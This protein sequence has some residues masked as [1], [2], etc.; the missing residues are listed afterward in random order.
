MAPL[1][2]LKLTRREHDILACLADG[3]TNRQIAEALYISVPTVQNHLQ[4]IFQKLHVTNRTQ[5]VVVAQRLGLLRTE[6]HQINH[7]PSR[8]TQYPANVL[9]EEPILTGTRHQ[10][11][12][13]A[14][15]VR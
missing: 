8:S 2:V 11:S 5:A 10:R 3:K 4:N 6:T 1:N 9:T 12:N 14:G 13:D 15:G 7:G